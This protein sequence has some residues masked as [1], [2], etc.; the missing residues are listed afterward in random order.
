MTLPT[1]ESETVI[2]GASAAGMA[3][4]ACLQRA[5]RRFVLL[6]AGHEVGS[7]WRR[8]Y[9]RL[10]LHTAK[11]LSSLPYLPFPRDV[12]RYPSR[13]QVVDYLDAYRAHFSLA[14]RFGQRVTSVKRDGDGWLTR[15]ED[16]A[17]RSRS[18][19]IATGYTRVPHRPSWPG[20]ERFTGEVLHS[21][22]YKNGAAWR[23][24]RV[25]VIGFGNSGGE[26][27]IDLCEHGAHPSLAVRGAVNVVPRDFLGLPILAWGIVL[28]V[29]PGWLADAIARLVAR[30]TIGRLDRLG[31]TPSGRGPV[32][33]IRRDGRIP[34]ID[35]GTVARIRRR[36]IDVLPGVES[37]TAGGARFV[38]GVER[39]F[40]AVVLATGYRPL[41]ASFLE[42]A[43]EV[44]DADGVPK[45]SGAET[46]PGLYF[47]GFY[48]APTGMLREIGREAKRIAGA[49]AR[50]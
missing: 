4:A 46:L 14:P 43:A 8:H 10:H 33:Q 1:V 18:V 24:R 36:E 22:E 2:V 3:T 30:I 12:P 7:A 19:V 31:L 11:A 44:L 47:C 15:S 5:G 26:I 27:A 45:Q 25:L 35:I 17:Y 40:D 32:T 34:L 16:T 38:G 41:L 49:I 9:E 20:L 37:F 48:V 21:S 39:E 13:A 42:P 29:L 50:R 6:E 28:S 23:G